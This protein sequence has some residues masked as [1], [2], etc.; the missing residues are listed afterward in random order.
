MTSF[1]RI[2]TI[3]DLEEI[4]DFEARILEKQIPDE[5]ERIFAQWNS[6]TRKEALEH[7]L[8]LGWSFL[9]RD[10]E[11]KSKW[12]SEGELLG[13]FIGQPLLFFEGQTQSL[14]VEHISAE[15]DEVFF[16]LGDLAYRLSREK[17]FQRV[18]LP[19]SDRAQMLFAPFKITSWKPDTL[20]I[21]TTKG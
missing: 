5:A 16:F 19:N 7:H 18:Y 21:R 12:S 15:N 8:G 2:T 3:H 13:Y 4:L 9:V 20:F 11:K 10:Q 14:W 17:H 1:S 6:R